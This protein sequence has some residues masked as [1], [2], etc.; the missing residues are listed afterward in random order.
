VFA[1]VPPD[2]RPDVGA[3]AHAALEQPAE[4][5]SPLSLE[6]APG[7]TPIF[8]DALLLSSLAKPAAGGNLPRVRLG[9]R[10][11]RNPGNLFVVKDFQPS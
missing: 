9:G 5:V 8:L 3:A 4:Q 10:T 11:A 6:S 2:R 7:E 1:T